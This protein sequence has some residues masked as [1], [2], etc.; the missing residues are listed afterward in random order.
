MAF[1]LADIVPGISVDIVDIGASPIDGIPPYKRLLDRDVARLI[2]FEPNPKMFAR[3]HETKAA[4]RTYLPYAV[5]DG[6]RHLYRFCQAPGMNSILQPN[7]ALYEFL[8]GFDEWGRVVSE[9][10][11]DTVRLDD[12]AEIARMDYLKIDI[13][14]AE[15]MVF[16]NAVRRLADC[17]IIQAEVEFVPMY[18]NQ[19]L[20]SD[21]DQFLRAQGF[22]I[23]RFFPL[24]SRAIKPM[25][26]K[27]KYSGFSQITWA[28]AIFIRDFTHMERL[29]DGQLLR[30]A[31]VLHDV[32]GS[33][34]VVLR[35]LLEHDRRAGTGY[36]A[37]YEERLTIERRKN[38]SP[39]SLHLHRETP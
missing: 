28:D 31:L 20:Y 21:V 39:L 23:H 19:P 5:G 1:S 24:T 10:E 18:V 27:D 34:D 17:L 35:L 30:L 32:Y 33:F 7:Q 4:G 37:V 16:E 38:L 22:M 11:I 8:H 9:T 15:L 6:G 14:G 36:A 2:G 25:V 3:L 12:V 13:Q 29:D 26:G